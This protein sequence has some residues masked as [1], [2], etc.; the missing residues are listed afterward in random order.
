MNDQD[1]R[2]DEAFEAMFKQRIH[3]II[4]KT[5]SELKAKK[6]VKFD[7][8]EPLT[9]ERVVEELLSKV[10]TK[11]EVSKERISMVTK[12]NVKATTTTV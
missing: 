10:N 3:S 12:P 8:K 2:N 11:R 4:E 6:S 1:L 9:E 5:E 7:S